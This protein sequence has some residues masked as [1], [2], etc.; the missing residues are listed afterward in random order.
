MLFRSS[1]CE[2][3]GRSLNDFINLAPK[4]KSKN[5]LE[6][7]SSMLTAMFLLRNASNEID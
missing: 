5:K 4:I 2:Y 6:T 3:V 1:C 7:N